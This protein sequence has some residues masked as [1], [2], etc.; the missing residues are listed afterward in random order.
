LC[1]TEELIAE[2]N[3]EYEGQTTYAQDVKKLEDEIIY[4]NVFEDADAIYTEILKN[5]KLIYPNL[6]AFSY[7]RKEFIDLVLEMSSTKEDID[8]KKDYD[9]DNA[10]RE[11]HITAGRVE[12]ITDR[13]QLKKHLRS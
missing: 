5:A 10:D 9:N 4:K 13:R 6:E 2:F 12:A 8:D 11:I 1:S 7:N 3:R